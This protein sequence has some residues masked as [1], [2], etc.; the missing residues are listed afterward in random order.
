MG[1]DQCLVKV[2]W[3]G[4]FVPVFWWMELDLVSLKDSAGS[5]S[6]F[7]GV[8]GFDMALGSLSANEQGCVPVCRSF[9]VRHWHC[10]LLAFGWDL[11]S[12]LRPLGEFSSINVPWGW[13]FSG[14]Q[15]PKLGSSTF[16]VQAWPPLTVGPRLHRSHSRED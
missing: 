4:R 2:S 7:W 14:I 3:F 6:V 10:S 8:Y 5:S 1:L 16:G 15:S 9:G 13:E 11:V 12:V